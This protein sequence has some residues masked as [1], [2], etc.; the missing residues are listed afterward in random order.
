MLLLLTKV[1]CQ[2][3]YRDILINPSEIFAISLFKRFIPTVHLFATTRL[4]FG[5]FSTAGKTLSLH[6]DSSKASLK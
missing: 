3:L 2:F 1:V 6:L 5:F 4:E